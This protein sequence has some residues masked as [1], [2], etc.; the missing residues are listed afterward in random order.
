MFKN[1][2]WLSL[3]K[4]K[5]NIAC[6]DLS[7]TVYF[8]RC[9][10]FLWQV[11]IHTKTKSQTFNSHCNV[12]DIYLRVRGRQRG[13]SC[14]RL[15]WL[16]GARPVKG[17]ETPSSSL[18]CG[19]IRLPA[20]ATDMGQAYSWVGQA[21]KCLQHSDCSTKNMQQTATE[22]VLNEHRVYQCVRGSRQG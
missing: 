21:A 22:E 18:I 8:F 15:G 14:P 4:G 19:S 3:L 6:I 20:H 1:A 16:P 10:P 9:E 17:N 7:A 12:F 11:I 5:T 13:G 2:G